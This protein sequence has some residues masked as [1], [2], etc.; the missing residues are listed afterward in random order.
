[1]GTAGKQRAFS[2]GNHQQTL[3]MTKIV[4]YQMPILKPFQPA[5]RFQLQCSPDIGEQRQ[6]SFQLVNRI[7]EHQTIQLPGLERQ[8]QAM[9]PPVI[10]QAVILSQ[11]L[12]TDINRDSGI[13][14]ETL[15]ASAVVSMPM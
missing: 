12:P 5:V 13:L 9:A 14:K 15:Y 7:S 2:A 10:P 3:L 1:M 4:L 8:P 6:P 11:C